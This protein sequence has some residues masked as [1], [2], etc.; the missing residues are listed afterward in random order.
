[1][2]KEEWAQRG[3]APSCVCSVCVVLLSVVLLVLS[4]WRLAKKR[5]GEAGTQS[6]RRLRRGRWADM[7]RRGTGP[8]IKWLRTLDDRHLWWG[9]VV[10]VRRFS[11]G[12]SAVCALATPGSS[13]GLREGL[14]KPSKHHIPAP[15]PPWPLPPNPRTCPSRCFN[16]PLG[17]PSVVAPACLLPPDCPS[18]HSPALTTTHNAVILSRLLLLRASSLIFSSLRNPHHHR[19]TPVPI[20]PPSHARQCQLHP[21]PHACTCTCTHRRSAVGPGH[22]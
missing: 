17:R 4:W 13:E 2:G 21:T 11:S 7:G 12:R 18:T 6:Q 22:C 16:C 3:A 9:Q 8:A 10:R 15:S 1:M 5:A 19:I 20:L 14:A